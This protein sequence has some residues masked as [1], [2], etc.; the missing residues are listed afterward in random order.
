M[1]V[2]PSCKAFELLPYSENM[3]FYVEL[4]IGHILDIVQ[5]F[6]YCP[7]SHHHALYSRP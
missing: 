5:G 2:L 4:K 1:I 3:D 7:D 6:C